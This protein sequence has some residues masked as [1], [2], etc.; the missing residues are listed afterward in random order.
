MAL[1]YALAA[2]LILGFYMLAAALRLKVGVDAPDW[3]WRRLEPQIPDFDP[4][5]QPRIWIHAVSVGEM[6]NAELLANSIRVKAP[7]SLIAVSSATE[8]GYAR[9]TAL[10]RADAAFVMPIDL[11]SR[12][13]PI[14]D[15]LRPD[16]IVLAESE[17]WPALFALAHERSVPIYVVNAT[18]S[19][20]SFR[21]HKRFRYVSGAT[22]PLIERTFT[23]DEA[24]ASKWIDLGA[25]P[26]RVEIAGSLKLAP[27]PD[28]PP[29]LDRLDDLPSAPTVTFGNV[30][31]EEF[32][33]IAPVLQRLA[34]E[35]PEFRVFLAPRHPDRFDPGQIARRLG[36]DVQFVSD[37]RAEPVTARQVWVNQMGVLTA[38]YAKSTAA[39]VCGTFCDVGGHD[40]AE[41]MHCGAVCIHGP[42]T[43]KQ[44]ALE[45]A[46]SGAQCAVRVRD[47]KGLGNAIV[48][49]LSDPATAASYS[50]RFRAAS[51]RASVAIESITE[52]LLANRD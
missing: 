34:A 47:A 6:K 22:I 31:P 39:V 15:A 46:L 4:A 44:R 38:L 16:A 10:D 41:P 12:L 30:H 25:D 28:A 14:F 52:A 3:L 33:V 49:L 45:A 48:S 36:P 35:H 5:R 43:E 21:R 18:M 9:A 7:R 27:P 40:L 26:G 11:R 8:G 17:L 1:V 20:R 13:L 19:E 24:S 42:R 32:D 29:R 50:A 37:I 23:Q 51:Q 2:R